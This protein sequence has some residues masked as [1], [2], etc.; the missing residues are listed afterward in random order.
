MKLFTLLMFVL[1]ALGGAGCTR[2]DTVK[3]L[4]AQSTSRHREPKPTATGNPSLPPQRNQD[5][6]LNQNLSQWLR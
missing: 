2:Q 3:S 6:S 4:P 5:Q 1:L